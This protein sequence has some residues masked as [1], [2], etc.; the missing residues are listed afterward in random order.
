MNPAPRELDVRPILRSGGEPFQAIMEAVSG[1]KPG[2]GLRLFAPFRP[3]PLFKVMESRGFGHAAKEI[4]GGDWEVLFTPNATGTPVEASAD[5]ENADTW[6][7][8]AEHLDLTEL[9]PPEPMVRI[10]AAAE[11]LQPGEVLFALLSRE[12]IFLFPEL[13][14]RGHQW[15][16][17]FDETRTTF[18]IFVRAGKKG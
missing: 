3:L 11:R 7:D 10:L 6:P 5:A 9:D 16:G 2:Q 13:A 18:R 4:E 1:L 15:A 12:P 14:K 17:N 8:P